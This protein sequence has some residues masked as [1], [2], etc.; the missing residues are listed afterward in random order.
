MRKIKN[1]VMSGFL[2]FCLFLLISSRATST[3]LAEFF[4]LQD[5]STYT[6][7]GVMKDGGDNRETRGIQIERVV[8]RAYQHPDGTNIYYWADGDFRIKTTMFGLGCFLLDDNGLWTI[9]AEDT[10]ELELI[11]NQKKHLLI[12]AELLP[13]STFSFDDE[14][15]NPKRTL[16]VEGFED[17]C[18]AAGEFDSCLKLRIHTKWPKGTE[19]NA[20][21]WLAKDVG[22]VKI[23]R[24][25]SLVSELI[26]YQISGGKSG[27]WD[28]RKK[29]VRL[30]QQ[31]GVNQIN[32]IVYG[33]SHPGWRATVYFSVYGDETVCEGKG[34]VKRVCGSLEGANQA[35]QL[36]ERSSEY[37]LSITI[38][39]ALAKIRID[40]D[41]LDTAKNAV[42]KFYSLPHESNAAFFTQVPKDAVP[43]F[44][45]H[46]KEKNECELSF[47]EKGYTRIVRFKIEANKILIIESSAFSIYS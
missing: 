43:Y 34:T 41:D 10:D 38:N 12:G 1:G 44:F 30:A 3:T 6:Y 31:E 40:G 24:S 5:G 17:V 27:A 37:F 15:S 23:H 19:E 26:D 39:E 11:Y 46:D 2:F 29:I 32:D 22:M 45:A 33:S 21:V 42:E 14:D 36:K 16:F 13:G 20:F 28:V 9:D 47:R 18:V 7:L 8:V 4:P 25:T 35:A